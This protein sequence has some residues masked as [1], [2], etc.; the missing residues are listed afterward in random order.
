M[1]IVTKT[2]RRNFIKLAAATTG[3][4]VLGFNCESSATSFNVLDEARLAA[5]NNFNS[6]LS[7]SSDNI[8]T[9]FF[10]QS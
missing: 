3:G 10:S 9:I 7:I 4:L 8:I 5:D 6:Y 1:E 2:N